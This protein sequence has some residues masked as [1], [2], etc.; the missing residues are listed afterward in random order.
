MDCLPGHDGQALP[1]TGLSELERARRLVLDHGWNTTC[2]QIL[3]AGI[4]R[5]HLDDAVV[6]YVRNH[7]TKI[8]AG[9]PVC[10]EESLPE[11]LRTF[12]AASTDSVC[13]FGAE[14]RVFRY[15]S[16]NGNYSYTVLGAQPVWSPA[17]WI[18]AV[19]GDASLRAQLNRARNKAVVVS[20]WDRTSATDNPAL[21]K[22]LGQWLSTRGLPEMHF[23]VEPDTLGFLSDRRVF[24]AERDG[25]PVGFTVLCPIPDRSGWLT[26]QF[27]RGKGAP[28]GTVELMVDAAIRQIGAEGAEM[29]TMGMVPLSRRVP[30]NPDDPGWL[31][32][33]MNRVRAHG[34][35]FYN[36]D[37]LEWFKAKF[38]PDRWDPIYAVST[39][40]RISVGT[41]NAIASAF[42]RIPPWLAIGIG[43]W[44][45]LKQEARWLTGR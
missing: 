34:R 42:T 16:A 25:H 43:A 24:V 10:P 45:A 40:P 15:A 30:R 3:N 23:L 12:E 41:L 37:G 31:R 22:V 4:Q 2:Y 35:R 21:R 7:R 38:H 14:E 29:V 13:Y 11:V 36:F 33:T 20:E 27:V 18:R 5:F 17:S 32:F 1:V 44:R 19:H 9:A 6:G 8:V 39:E 28:N 26:E